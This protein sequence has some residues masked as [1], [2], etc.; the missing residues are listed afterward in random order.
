MPHNIITSA[1]R[2]RRA[3][4]CVFT[5]SLHTQT[6]TRQRTWVE[7]GRGSTQLY[8]AQRVRMWADR[9]LDLLCLIWS[10]CSGAISSDGR[11]LLAT[12]FLASLERLPVSGASG[13]INTAT[14]SV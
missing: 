10:D 9:V 11:D 5:L 4:V 2:P 1:N 12:H 13:G 3:D 14:F 6:H 7:G 8:A